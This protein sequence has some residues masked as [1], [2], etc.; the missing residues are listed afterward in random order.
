METQPTACINQPILMEYQQGENNNITQCW[1]PGGVWRREEF[2]TMFRPLGLFLAH[3]MASQ[4]SSQFF[5]TRDT[6]LWWTNSEEERTPWIRP[7]LD[8]GV[9]FSKIL[10]WLSF[11]CEMERSEGRSC[12][13]MPQTSDVIPHRTHRSVGGWQR[14]DLASRSS[15]FC[16]IR[17]QCLKGEREEFFATFGKTVFYFGAHVTFPPGN[18]VVFLTFILKPMKNQN[19]NKVSSVDSKLKVLNNIDCDNM[20]AVTVTPTL[21]L[22]SES[23]A[24]QSY[25]EWVPWGFA[26]AVNFTGWGSQSLTSGE[27]TDVTGV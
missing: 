4:S 22:I 11:A 27:A 23:C 17:I 21:V 8:V 1:T 2:S 13:E 6:E 20:P 25:L 19:N 18:L 3:L 16:R 7:S 26:S 10:Q 14:K 9:C 15:A 24:D 5:W 12:L